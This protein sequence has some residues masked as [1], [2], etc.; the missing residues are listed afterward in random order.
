MDMCYPMLLSRWIPYMRKVRSLEG[1]KYLRERY[2]QASRGF[3]LALIALL[4]R[5]ETNTLLADYRVKKR[6]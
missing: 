5:N 1:V 4:G 2:G 6:K 3:W